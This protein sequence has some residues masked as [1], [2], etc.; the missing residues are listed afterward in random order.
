MEELSEEDRSALEDLCEANGVTEGT[1]L[2]N[3]QRVTRLEMFLDN[4]PKMRSVLCFPHLVGLRG[5]LLSRAWTC[6]QHSDACQVSN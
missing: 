5:V 4:F 3:V 1:L 6:R 2:N